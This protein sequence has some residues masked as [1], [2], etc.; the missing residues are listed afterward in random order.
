MTPAE[1]ALY[2][3]MTAKVETFTAWMKDGSGLVT[4]DDRTFSDELHS[5]TPV[6]PP[7]PAEGA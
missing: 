6:A 7:A 4:V 2:R 1:K 3:G 5:L